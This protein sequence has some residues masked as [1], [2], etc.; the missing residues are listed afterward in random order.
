MIQCCPFSCVLGRDVCNDIKIS[1]SPD[2]RWGGGGGGVT[3]DMLKGVLNKGPLH[4]QYVKTYFLH[5][6]HSA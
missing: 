2:V 4:I 1:E 6:V 5:N 3:E